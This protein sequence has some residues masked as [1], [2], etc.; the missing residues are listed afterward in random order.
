MLL[1]L[2]PMSAS[3]LHQFGDREVVSEP[4]IQQH[5]DRARELY[6][7]GDYDG[8]IAAFY[9][10]LELDPQDEEAHYGAG[11]SLY[12]KGDFD[13]AVAALDWALEL[14]PHDKEAHYHRGRALYNKGDDDGAIAAFDR[15]LDLDPKDK[16]VAYDRARA[17]Y[18]KADNWG[19]L[20]SYD[21]TLKLDPTRAEAHY[22]RGR[23]LFNIAEQRRLEVEFDGATT[24][25]TT[26]WRVSKTTNH[27]VIKAT[28]MTPPVGAPKKKELDHATDF[29]SAIKSF[30]RA[31]ELDPGFRDA[32][33]NRGYALQYKDDHDGAVSSFIKAVQLEQVELTSK[34]A[35]PVSKSNQ[36]NQT[37]NKSA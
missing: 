8:A 11:V 37:C 13:G 12:N 25:G 20:T 33:Y 24:S 36:S 5:H 27:K 1:L 23:A 30:D 29:D 22:G 18:N 21:K 3:T 26:T 17:L 28:P 6:N 34:H 31:L 35:K 15:A 14:D 10:A 16:E 7:K 32:H 2:L 4:D 9:Q 19:M